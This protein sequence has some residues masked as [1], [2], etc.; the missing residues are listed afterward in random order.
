MKAGLFALLWLLIAVPAM[1]ANLQSDCRGVGTI[2]TATMAA[3]G[4]M[5]L[6]LHSPDGRALVLAYPRSDTNYARM[7]SHIGGM[8][9]GER[10]PV[11][12]FC[13]AGPSQ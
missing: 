2:G 8:Q 9:P 6:N 3:D 5:T 11:P 12:A 4:T 7:L 13:G 1:A 10:K